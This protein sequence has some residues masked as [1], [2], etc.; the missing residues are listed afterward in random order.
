MIIV[1]S[2]YSSFT[3]SA[4]NQPTYFA[5][6]NITL[7]NIIP[8]KNGYTFIGWSLTDT[9]GHH[10]YDN[11]QA[12]ETFSIYVDTDITYTAYAQWELS[13]KAYIY[14]T[15]VIDGVATPSWWPATPYIYTG[16]GGINGWHEA[17]PSIYTSSG[18]K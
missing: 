9:T 6:E 13:K 17:T 7:S 5:N 4:L 16:S 14:A 15:K 12:G 8:V 11:K 3:H 1:F 10:W 18:W 2:L